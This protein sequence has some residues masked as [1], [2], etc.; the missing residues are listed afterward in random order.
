GAALRETLLEARL[1]PFVA[2]DELV[3]LI[4]L[5]GKDAAPQAPVVF[6]R[7]LHERRPALRMRTV[8]AKAE[9]EPRE[10]P[11][12]RDDVEALGPGEPVE[13]DPHRLAHQTAS[14]VAPDQI[15]APNG[16]GR[17]VG[18][19]HVGLDACPVLTDRGYRGRADE[20]EERM[21]ACDVE[22]D[23]D[24]LVL[25]ELDDERMAAFVCEHAVVELDAL[26]GDEVAPLED[27]R[28]KAAL[29]DLRG[30]LQILEQI[31][32]RRLQ[33]RGAMVF[34][35]LRKRVEDRDR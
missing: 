13:R 26:P 7:D 25:F 22:S 28:T 12:R 34:G 9:A 32:R 2:L 1:N 24:R 16:P 23:A 3:A 10:V 29:E 15:G 14:T 30:H 27:G 4:A 5:G 18:G 33:G 6:A 20:R 11:M 19:P 35:R 8:I 31:Q 21:T 17:S